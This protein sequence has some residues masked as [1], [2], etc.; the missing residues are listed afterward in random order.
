M[1]KWVLTMLM[2]LL[3]AFTFQNVPRASKVSATGTEDLLVDYGLPEDVPR[4]PMPENSTAED[5]L[6]TTNP[7][8]DFA[9]PQGAL[10]EVDDPEGDHPVY[11]L[12]FGDE[13][14]RAIIRGFHVPYT[15]K[16]NRRNQFLPKYTR[17]A[18]WHR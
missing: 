2:L 17:M 8:S 4:E 18:R 15:W 9:S 13:E 3:L 6:N 7:Y 10:D 12:I 11:V 14:E 16:P 5:Y 1:K